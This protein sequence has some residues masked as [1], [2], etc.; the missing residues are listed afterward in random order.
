MLEGT[1]ELTSNPGK[2]TH[3][4]IN[5]PL[6]NWVIFIKI[7]LKPTKGIGIFQVF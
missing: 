7:R 6:T 3:V 4:F 1:L 2:G 5:I